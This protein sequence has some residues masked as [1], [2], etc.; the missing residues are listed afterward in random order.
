[1]VDV[2]L[3]GQFPNSKMAGA[4]KLGVSQFISFDV[5]DV[6]VPPVVYVG[7]DPATVTAVTLSGSNLVAT[8]TGTTSLD[9]GAKVASASGKTSG[10]Y[11]FETKMTS[12]GALSG[13]SMSSGIATTAATY[14]GLGTNGAAGAVC[15]WIGGAIYATGNAG[16]GLG[17]RA[18]GETLGIAVD[19]DNRKIWFR[20]A[21]SGNWNGLAIGSQNPVGAVGGAIIPAGTIVPVVTFGGSGGIAGT[22]N[23]AN[24]G[25][26]AFIGAVPSG[27]T[28]GWTQ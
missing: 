2:D 19:L 15:Y 10:K 16:V 4:V 12:A 3:P 28:S 17:G 21:P 6:V 27:F 18:S 26:T 23:T 5:A 7:F 1:M 24:F 8:N 11:Y 22:V 25:A 13:T 14:T 20:V 9:Q